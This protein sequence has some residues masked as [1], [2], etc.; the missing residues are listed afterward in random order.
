M[1]CVEADDGGVFVSDDAGATWKRISEDR[2]LRQRAFYYIALY[3]DPKDKDTVYVLNTGFYK[4]TDGGKTYK[5]DPSAARRQPRSVDCIQRLRS[6]G[7][8]Q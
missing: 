8:Q 3:A 7:Q 1:P 6:D 2:R 4:S 5:T